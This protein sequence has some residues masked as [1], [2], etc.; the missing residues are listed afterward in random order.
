MIEHLRNSVR[1]FQRGNIEACKRYLIQYWQT[2]PK[3]FMVST[4]PN[5]DIANALLT[6]INSGMHTADDINTPAEKCD[7]C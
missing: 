7:D 1:A 5:D 4:K 6:L 2:R 3:A